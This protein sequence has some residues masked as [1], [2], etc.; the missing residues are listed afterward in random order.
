MSFTCRPDMLDGTWF[1]GNYT[2]NPQSPVQRVVSGR[3]SSRY[4]SIL[5]LALA[6]PAMMHGVVIEQPPCPPKPDHLSQSLRT[7]LKMGAPGIALPS[8]SSRDFL[9]TRFFKAF[10][11]SRNREY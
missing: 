9:I 2:L 5:G 4:H 6:R 8:W 7:T 11:L 10:L 3:S 1:L